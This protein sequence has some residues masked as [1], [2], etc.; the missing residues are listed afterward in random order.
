MRLFTTV[1]I[2]LVWAAM[3]VLPLGMILAQEPNPVRALPD[4]VERGEIFNVT[5]TFT[6]PVDSFV[7]G[8][9]EL[10]PDGWNVSD[11]WSDPVAYSK[12]TDNMAEY[13]WFYG[14]YP[15]GTNFT[16]SYK[17]KVPDNAS[18]GYH[19]FSGQL[20][21]G[22]GNNTPVA[23]DSQVEVKKPTICF[24]PSIDF[25][26]ALGQNPQNQTLQLWS[27]TPCML[28]WTLSDDADYGGH[29]WLSENLTSGNC[30][31]VHSS[32]A[33]PVNTSGM[34]VGDYTANITIESPDANNSPQKVT[35]NLYIRTTG[36]LK[37]QVNFI[38][39]GA[40]GSDKW[41]E[42]FVVK[43]FDNA[44]KFEMGWSPINATTN[45]TGV[46]TISNVTVGTYD[47]GIKNRTCLSEVETNVTMTA[48]NFTVVNFGTIREGD[49]YPPGDDR[50]NID[51]YGDILV[52]YNQ[53]YANGDFDRDGKVDI[54][55]YGIVIM[56]YGQKGDLYGK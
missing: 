24:T 37:G 44:T 25:Y 19:D 51:D 5:V 39:R 8:L 56:N 9:A 17:V 35:V 40:P 12:A 34:P 31:N 49:C 43:F 22:Q 53:V 1:V 10:A 16:V 42:P 3:V 29:D 20:Y 46:F 26:A 52:H 4:T 30:T 33:V 2:V 47:I 14:P 36:T 7:P 15:N 41:V 21:Y 28:N 6:A 38:G 50:V 13:T 55:D 27:S 23:G 45:N 18:E 11:L 54:D 48:G 32:V